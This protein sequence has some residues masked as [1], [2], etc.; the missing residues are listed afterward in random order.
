MNLQPAPNSTQPTC[1]QSVL[2]H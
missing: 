2:T 1:R